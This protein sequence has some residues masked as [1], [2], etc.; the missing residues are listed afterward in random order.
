MCPRRVLPTFDQD[1]LNSVLSKTPPVHPLYH[2]TTQLGLLGIVQSEEIWA[3]HHQ[4]LN[5]RQE[6]LHAKEL[7]LG[8]IEKRLTT[9]RR[10]ERPVLEEMLSALDL[11]GHEDV[12]LYVA[13]FSEQRD[14]LSQWRAYGAAT[15]GFAVG[16]QCDR[17]VLPDG[18]ILVRCIY[19]QTEQDKIVQAIVS[20]VLARSSRPALFSVASVHLRLILH[21]LALTLKHPKFKEE[22]EWRIIS[23]V[24]MDLA[25]AF[26][27]VEETK[28]AF[29]PGK[30]V[31]TPYRC[32]PLKDAGDRFP[33]SQVVV[34]PN[35]NPQQARR[36]VQ[37][38]LNSKSFNGV[39]VLD[40]DIP[41]RN[42]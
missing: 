1:I 36:S 20:E 11:P 23:P 17:L 16:F 29:R 9:A 8:E 27:V 14:S 18:F 28:L 7:V 37:S 15:S 32:I 42:W 26:P 21:T 22:E 33:L 25:P 5:D 34:G 10:N 41:Y 30:S 12:N 40:S 6:Y 2:Y 24:L 3:T 31:L 35:P 39:T 38:L 4:C 19:D 13:S